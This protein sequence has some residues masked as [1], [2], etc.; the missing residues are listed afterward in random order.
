[1][2]RLLN[3][4]LFTRNRLVTLGAVSL[5]LIAGFVAMPAEPAAAVACNKSW[6]A[7]VSGDW[8]DGTK[9]T[10]AGAPAGTDDVC[11]TVDGTYTVTLT[12]SGSAQSLELGGTTAALT[13]TLNVLG[14]PGGNATLFLGANPSV[15]TAHGALTMDTTDGSYSM[16]NNSGSLTNSGVFQTVNGAGVGDRYIRTS[17][18]NEAPGAI[19]ID[20]A[21]SLAD[22]AGKSLTNSGTFTT[23]ATGAFT[24]SGGTTFTNAAGTLTNNGS[25]TQSGGTFTQ[26]G[27]ITNGA[28]DVVLAYSTL[29]DSV[30][31]G[32]F[33]LRG[34]SNLSGTIPAG[35]TVTLLGGPSGGTAVSL[36]GGTVVNNG[37]L[38]MDSTTAAYSLVQ[39][40]AITNNGSMVF[41]ATAASPRYLRV[42]VTNSA[43]GTMTVNSSNVIQDASTTTTNNG[44]FTINASGVLAL[45]AGSVFTNAAPLTNSGA[46]NLSGATFNQNAGSVSGNEVVIASST[47]VDSVGTGAF[48]L[49]GNS[50]LSGTIPAG[51]TVT[52]LGGPSVGTVISLGGGTVVNNGTLIMDS[53]D[54]SYSLVQSGAITNNGSMVF[55]A[56][57]ASPRYLRVPLTNSATGTIAVN[58]AD[59]NQDAA[60]AITNNGTLV[61]GDGGHL[62]LS[63]GSSIVN[64]GGATLG[65]TVN[66]GTGVSQITGGPVTLGGSRLLI[67]TIGSPVLS[68]VY[69]PVSAATVSGS[70]GSLEFGPKAYTVGTTASTVT[71]TVGTPF[72]LVG[73]NLSPKADIPA[74]F[75]VATL[76]DSTPAS[77]Y[78]VSIDWGDSSQSAGTATISGTGA[79]IKGKHGYAAV[80]T[81]TVTTTVHGSDG[82]TITKTGIATVVLPAAPTIVTVTPS[83]RA[84]N[85]TTVLTITG[86][87]LTLNFIP[88]FSNP[89]V[90]VLT[91]TW[92]SATKVTVKVKVAAAAAPGAGNV[93]IATIG[94]STTCVGC[95]T[96]TAAPKITTISPSP[97]HGFMTNVTVTGTGFQAGL[98]VTTNI[99]GAALGA[100]TGLTATSFSIQITVPIGTAPGSYKLTV[101]NLD[102]G[103]ASKTITVL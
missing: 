99:P 34:T 21:S 73:K 44:S 41:G 81:Y 74:T 101:K 80:G 103:V 65:F 19:K 66:A 16:V 27:G 63:A 61:V 9:W 7:A 42:A 12:A 30:G 5:V 68:T 94:G 31:T 22:L 78:T 10:P 57:T 40:G 39:S 82:T 90:T 23:S 64:S 32:A 50:N 93:S 1:M 91:K 17:I 33:S 71:V 18:T 47:L 35:Q 14:G 85:T 11:I 25:F 86:T 88:T 46:L 100:V 83:V 75:T 6:T 4:R 8:S 60:T 53:T 13:E 2:R 36:G 79:T 3:V 28:N 62:F 20:A 96:V 89:G 102:G 37:T 51:Q 29:V 58:S 54:A 67:N 84:Q 76:T 77:S 55:G 70:F 43:S 59:V 98:V 48:S 49:R 56:T 38:I 72:V 52:L 87:N 45:T 15:I 92:I 69:T 97:V 95:F 24:A 26:S